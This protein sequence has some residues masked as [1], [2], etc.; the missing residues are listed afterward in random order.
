MVL[1]MF[2]TAPNHNFQLAYKRPY[3]VI[4]ARHLQTIYPLRARLYCPNLGG[5]PGLNV[6]RGE[7]EHDSTE[8][9]VIFVSRRSCLCPRNTA[10]SGQHIECR[11]Q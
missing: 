7:K 9:K 11:T 8:T 10:N 6:T 2:Y 1:D 3:H 5:K 4:K